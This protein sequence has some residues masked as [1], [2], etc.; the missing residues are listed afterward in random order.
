MNKKG[1]VELSIGTI[2]IIVLAMAML[3]LG[4][5]LVKNIFSGSTEAVTNLN[6]GVINEINNLFTKSDTRL[7]IYPTTAKITLAQ[8]QKDGGFAFSIKNNDVTAHK[9]LYSLAVDSSFEIAK[10][11][12]GLRETE[13]N[14][15]IVIP[16]GSVDIPAGRTM[17]APELAVISIPESAPPCTIPYKLTVFKDTRGLDNLYDSRTIYVTIEGK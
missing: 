2:V 3:I 15:W 9:F 17:T 7:A 5:V 12:G 4:L 14:S 13:A 11:C 10:K 6:K 16:E 1:A 8:A